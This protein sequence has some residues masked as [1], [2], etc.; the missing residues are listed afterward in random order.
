M[1]TR[2][3]PCVSPCGSRIRGIY[4]E[5]PR[6]PVLPP[7]KMINTAGAQRRQTT[8]RVERSVQMNAD[9]FLAERTRL[10]IMVPKEAKNELLAT[11]DLTW[12]VLQIL[13]K[14]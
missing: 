6:A 1:L 7:I 12:F 8:R 10:K 11:E 3:M 9:S 14:A 13:F 4:P 2:A 5:R